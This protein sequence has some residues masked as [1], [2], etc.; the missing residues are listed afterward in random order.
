VRP[1]QHTEEEVRPAQHTEEEVRPAQHTEEEVRP[2]QHTEEEVRPAQH[3]EEEVRPAQ[4]TEAQHTE[5]RACKRHGSQYWGPAGSAA[6]QIQTICDN[7]QSKLR[8]QVRSNTAVYCVFTRVAL[9]LQFAQ[10][11]RSLFTR[12][13]Q[14]KRAESA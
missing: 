14:Q 12:E 2:A 4:H 6:E 13:Q 5:A 10:R 9:E 11:P 8:A 7:K 1:A 3:T